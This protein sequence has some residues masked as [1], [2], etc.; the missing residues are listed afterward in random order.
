MYVPVILSF[1]WFWQ[2]IE[3]GEG[4]H[5]SPQFIASWLERKVVPNCSC[6]LSL[7]GLSPGPVRSLLT[8]AS[9]Y[10]N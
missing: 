9:E 2:I 4:D 7:S 10:Q 8:P 1:E 6:P 3:P 5:G